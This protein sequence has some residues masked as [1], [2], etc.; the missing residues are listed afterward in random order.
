MA[1]TDTH[2]HLDD[3]RYKDDLDEVLKR[4][5]ELSFILNPGCD[6]KT[7]KK[8]VELANRYDK[9]Y[10]A[11]GFHPGDLGEYGPRALNELKSM[12]E[13]PKVVAIG[14]IGLD[15]HYPDM[16]EK[17]LQKRAFREQIELAGELGL[18][19]IVHDREAHGDSLEIIRDYPGIPGVFHSFSG[20]AEMAR[21]LIDRGLMISVGGVLTFKNARKLPD[22]VKEIPL[23]HIMLETDGPYLTPEPYRGKRN[24]PVNVRLVAQ[25]I[26]ELKDLPVQDVI[27]R[28]ARNAENFFKIHENR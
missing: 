16:F 27:E 9:I 13:D 4:A 25:K 5:D 3:E 11:V 2:V 7:S 1:L 8:A 12:A 19:Y 22:I 26:A 17:D 23:E 18:P 14:E 20:S 24:E 28:T 21:E 10:A 15:Y 6:L